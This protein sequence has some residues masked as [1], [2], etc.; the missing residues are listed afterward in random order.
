MVDVVGEQE[1]V[2]SSSA[3]L[4]CGIDQVEG[5]SVMMVDETGERNDAVTPVRERFVGSANSNDVSQ[6]ILGV[7]LTAFHLLSYANQLN[8]LHSFAQKVSIV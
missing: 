4:S 2:K 1:Q 6:G 5:A 8:F 7:L 3:S